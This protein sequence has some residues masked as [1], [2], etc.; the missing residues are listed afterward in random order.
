MGP[1]PCTWLQGQLLKTQL[2]CAWKVLVQNYVLVLLNDCYATLFVVTLVPTLRARDL[3]ECE[4][5]TP[6]VT[7]AWYFSRSRMFSFLL[8]F[9]HMTSFWELVQEHI[10][11][12]YTGINT[13]M[14]K[15]YPWLPIATTQYSWKLPRLPI[16]RV[17]EIVGKELTGGYLPSCQQQQFILDVLALTGV[18]FCTVN[19][20]G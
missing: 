12:L 6:S 16:I 17:W 18:I 2:Q 3:G 13:L 10:C 1:W 20:S 7:F 8:L 5:Q 4:T 14:F 9:R 15:E 19:F 11:A